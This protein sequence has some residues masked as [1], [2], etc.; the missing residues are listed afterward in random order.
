MAFSAAFGHLRPHE[1]CLVDA[2]APAGR[3]DAFWPTL[4]GMLPVS[5][6]G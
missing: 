6:S 2:L 3:Q 1:Q 5:G 4:N